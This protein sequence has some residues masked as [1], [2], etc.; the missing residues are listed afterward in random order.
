MVLL[1]DCLLDLIVGS[2]VFVF[3]CS[4]DSQVSCLCKKFEFDLCKFGLFKMV[5]GN[6]YLLVVYVSVDLVM[7]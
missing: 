5:W 6:G 7:L 4:I 2:D 3:D 1:C